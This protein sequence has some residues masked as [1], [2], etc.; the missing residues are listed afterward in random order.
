MYSLVLYINPPISLVLLGY[1]I[2]KLV[3]RFVLKV[4]EPALDKRGKC[5]SGKEEDEISF[6][7]V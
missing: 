3:R 1:G 2:Y 6:D 4:R 7:A 5:R